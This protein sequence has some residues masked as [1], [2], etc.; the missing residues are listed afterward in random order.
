MLNTAERTQHERFQQA[1]LYRVRAEQLRSFHEPWMDVESHEM[2]GRIARD[3][4]R[5][6][7]GLDQEGIAEMLSRTKASD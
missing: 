2:L 1:P 7:D 5:M 3:F 4:E 6:A